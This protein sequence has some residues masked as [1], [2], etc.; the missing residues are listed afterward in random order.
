[1]I[2]RY[3]RGLDVGIANA[4]HRGFAGVPQPINPALTLLAQADWLLWGDDALDSGGTLTSWPAEAGPTV[5]LESS[6]F[7]AP[8]VVTVA[9][10]N[11]KKA[12]VFVKGTGTCLD[13][14]GNVNAVASNHTLLMFLDP[15]AP[16]QESATAQREYPIAQD[17]NLAG[18]LI[19]AHSAND[20]RV[21]DAYRNA[22]FF[23]AAADG[24]DTP[25]VGWHN[26][27]RADN[28]NPYVMQIAGPQCRVDVLESGAGGVCKYFRDGVLLGTNTGHYLTQRPWA[29][30]TGKFRIGMETTATA[31]NDPTAYGGKIYCILHW[32]R[33][34]TDVEVQTIS[35]YVM[36]R[37]NWTARN[38]TLPNERAGIT[39]WLSSAK[40]IV[41]GTKIPTT[42]PSWPDLVARMSLSSG[43]MG[44]TGGVAD[45]SPNQDLTRSSLIDQIVT[46]D[47]YTVYQVFFARSV[48]TTSATTNAN[49]V[50][51]SDSAGRW[52]LHFRDAG[53]GTYE[54]RGMHTQL[55]DNAQKTVTVSGLQLNQWNLAIW[56]YDGST[57]TMYLQLN[58]GTVQSI[59]SVAGI[60]LLTGSLAF[61]GR[62]ADTTV[63]W[64]GLVR[65]HA[66]YNTF[67]N[68]TVV[69]QM[70]VFFEAMRDA[71]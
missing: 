48:S 55:G 23:T 19:F 28:G 34:L 61:A 46:Q 42:A 4:M 70:R 18:R 8:T 51:C 40:N 33:A 15:D 21:V 10:R 36:A 45:F 44:V 66:V 9:A 6:P 62:P 35:A 53:G 17:Y 1:M 47:A 65:E 38:Y 60:N 12:V 5:I 13:V 69:A 25:N 64:D 26:Y 29:K 50:T 39:Q 32:S 27:I 20:Q 43:S 41:A 24:D 7:I 31:A 30:G 59:G 52:G 3:A 37:Y 16:S 49:D 11:N 68:D 14:N 58:S 2:D 22:G 56:R 54:L 57:D 67:H 63:Q 71:A